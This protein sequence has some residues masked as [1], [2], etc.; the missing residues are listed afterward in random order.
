MIIAYFPAYSISRAEERR[1]MAISHPKTDI[2]IYEAGV[3]ATL[4]RLS[5]TDIV[6]R[7]WREDYTVWKPEPTEITYRL[8]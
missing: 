8:G 4:T 3:K 5:N 1:K 2:G 7:I 6:R